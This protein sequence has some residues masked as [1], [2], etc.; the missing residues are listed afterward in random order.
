MRLIM[1]IVLIT[2]FITVFDAILTGRQKR[3]EITVFVWESDGGSR[4]TE[5]NFTQFVNRG[6]KMLGGGFYPPSLKGVGW[7]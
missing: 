2:D 7:L 6:V 3:S 4:F 1:I 5:S